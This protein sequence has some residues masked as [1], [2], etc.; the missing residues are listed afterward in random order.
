MNN[1]VGE[2]VI[3]RNSL[4]LQQEHLQAI[5]L[6][7]QQGLE[8]FQNLTTALE[9]LSDNTSNNLSSINSD[10]NLSSSTSPPI[11]NQLLNSDRLF[12]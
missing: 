4:A 12:D 3:N 7:V 2:L 5:L 1:L 10:A 9:G 11:K 8:Q 6:K